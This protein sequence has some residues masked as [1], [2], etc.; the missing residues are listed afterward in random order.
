MKRITDTSLPGLKG[1]AKFEIQAFSA[2]PNK[3]F[4]PGE[5]VGISWSVPGATKVTLIDN[6]DGTRLEDLQA[7][8][9]V[10]VSPTNTTT[11][12]L[13]AN[14]PSGIETAEIVVTL[15]SEK[16][17][18]QWELS[19]SNSEASSLQQA[20]KAQPLKA[21]QKM[22]QNPDS[23]SA[24]LTAVNDGSVY[25]GSFDGNYY[26]FSAEGD[27]SWTLEDAGVVM[28]Q[29]AVLGN[30]IFVGANSPEGGRVLALKPDKSVM[31]EIGTT[32][33]VIASPI[34]NTD[35]GILYAVTYDGT[36]LALDNASGN[37]L[38]RYK[39]PDGETVN[40][41]PTLSEDGT[42]LYI[43]STNHRVF[44]LRTEPEPKAVPI[45][46][47]AI[48]DGPVVIVPKNIPA[49]DPSEPELEL[50]TLLWQRDLQ[51]ES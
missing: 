35:S 16:P 24:S 31:W 11:Y 13:I 28:N 19:S 40:A 29:A 1:D 27:M 21:L 14:G 43:H 37:E 48:P 39:L 50:P 23:I 22:Q 34:I 30:I 41:S 3:L 4:R 33:G 42:V 6:S 25:Q 15:A 44:A 12:T 2:L 17:I 47:I 36:V 7:E 46:V 26:Q 45:I 9:L 8:G 51:T 10:R 38:W 20:Q 5:P 32:S 49:Q 18:N